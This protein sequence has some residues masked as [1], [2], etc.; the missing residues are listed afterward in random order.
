MAGGRKSKG[1]RGARSGREKMPQEARHHAV[2]RV[3]T[4]ASGWMPTAVVLQGAMSSWHAVPRANSPMC[5]YDGGGWEAGGRRLL[6]R[7]QSLQQC[8]R[9]YHVI[10]R[11]KL[12]QNVRSG[13]GI[14]R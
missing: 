9:I 10:S 1:E 8:T 5:T 3:F 12:A 14:Y 11:G 7:H 13:D 6:V 2:R 4:L